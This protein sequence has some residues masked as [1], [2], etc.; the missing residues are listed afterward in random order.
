M[1][2]KGLILESG[3]L[4][5]ALAAMV[6]CAF[7]IRLGTEATPLALFLA[8]VTFWAF[9]MLTMNTIVRLFRF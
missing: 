2:D 1:K 5:L 4:G 6:V 3:V 9:F 7:Q 8:F